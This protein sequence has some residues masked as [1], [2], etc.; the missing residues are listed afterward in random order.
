MKKF[1]S[2]LSIIT[3]LFI[4]VG[5]NPLQYEGNNKE[6]F[7]VAA[8]N[9]LGG[10]Y[11]YSSR[12]KV[13]EEDNQ[14][15][16][17]FLYRFSSVLTDDEDGHNRYI[18]ALCICQHFDDK[19]TY[20]YEDICAIV[21]T[22]S[23]FEDSEVEQLKKIND[24]NEPLYYGKMTAR[25]YIHEGT[26]KRIC[27]QSL[28]KSAEEYIKNYNKSAT[29]HDIRIIYIDT[30]KNGKALFLANVYD[31]SVKNNFIIRDTIKL[32]VVIVQE[33]EIYDSKE[34]MEI[35]NLLDY[36]LQV[37]EFKIRNGWRFE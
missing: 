36:Q 31:E 17:L 18:Y 28:T 21:K 4:C 19:D 5:C 32:Y 11:G 29:E 20:F 23:N 27:S 10:D 13:I 9:V 7:T 3:I 25:E 35:K 34:V 30:D 26:S 14:G 12:T 6:L 37:H 1:F 8:H 24:W 15:R 22:E 2:W 33:N 16:I